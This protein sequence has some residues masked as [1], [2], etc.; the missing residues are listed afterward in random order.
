MSLD[1]KSKGNPNWTPGKSGN[2]HGR[3]EGAK[4]LKGLLKVAANLAGKK[5][6]PVDELV[7]LADAAELRG[8]KELSAKIWQDLLKY[9]EPQKK[10]VETAPEKPTTPDE[11]LENAQKLLEQMEQIG[12]TATNTGATSS[13]QTGLDNG[14][15]EV[16]PE[17]NSEGD[18]R[19][20]KSV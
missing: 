4:S 18:V 7:R 16:S 8:E 20:D 13:N 19:R 11:S 3:P 2:P 10:A 1:K 12:T 9:C 15:P 14:T 17:A 6:H 5:R